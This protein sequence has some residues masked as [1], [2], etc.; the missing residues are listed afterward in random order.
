MVGR[1]EIPCLE[2]QLT[3]PKRRLVGTRVIRSFID[4]DLETPT[5]LR[6]QMD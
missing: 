5:F 3:Q 2:I 4:D 1:G 6:K